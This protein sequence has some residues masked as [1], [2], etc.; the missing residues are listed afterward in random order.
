VANV[1]V[2]YLM[3]AKKSGVFVKVYFEKAYDLVD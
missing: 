2:D 3:K 1:S